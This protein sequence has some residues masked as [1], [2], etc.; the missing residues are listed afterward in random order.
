M[1]SIHHLCGPSYP[2]L[3]GALP[4]ETAGAALSAGDVRVLQD[5]RGEPPPYNTSHYPGLQKHGSM[6]PSNLPTHKVYSLKGS[7]RDKSIAKEQHGDETVKNKSVIYSTLHSHGG[8]VMCP[9]TEVA[10]YVIAEHSFKDEN[11]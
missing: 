2:L 3:P 11:T 9:S 10:D 7:F 6:H 1:Q 8:C 4:A 5:A